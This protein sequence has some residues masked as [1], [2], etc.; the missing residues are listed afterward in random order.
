MQL[1][2]WHAKGQIQF[3][4][5][6]LDGIESFPAAYDLV[7]AGGNHGKTLICLEPKGGLGSD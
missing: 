5:H 6:V 4:E 3:R 7:F 2:G 1:A